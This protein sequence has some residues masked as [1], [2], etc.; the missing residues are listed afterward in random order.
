MMQH[1]PFDGAG[2]PSR[3][4]TAL[5]VTCMLAT[6]A[7]SATSCGWPGGGATPREAALGW[8]G[9]VLRRDAEGVA[10]YSAPNADK[11]PTD[12]H[13]PND[14]TG[15]EP[16]VVHESILDDPRE[17]DVVFRRGGVDLGRPI[18]IG[19]WMAESRWRAWEL[20]APTDHQRSVIDKTIRRVLAA[21]ASGDAKT[22]EHF[23]VD[24]ASSRQ[25]VFGD[26]ARS[27]LSGVAITNIS[28]YGVIHTMDAWLA[29]A[30]V[31]T[32]RSGRR[33][34]L[35]LELSGRLA[36]DN[37]DIQSTA[38]GTAADIQEIRRDAPRR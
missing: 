6:V 22:A 37:K 1:T 16:V 32:G 14:S 21:L 10:R 30:D 20:V 8:A 36:D 17:I 13:V 29:T 25:V 38:Y 2:R 24:Y 5:T 15:V 19:T 27:R 26:S 35:T 12:V 3:V 4:V 18:R 11:L 33:A 28:R 7:V 9:A 23:G 34:D 31:V